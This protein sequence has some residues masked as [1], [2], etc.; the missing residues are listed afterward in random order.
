[1]KI[2]GAYHG[3][4]LK[5]SAKFHLILKISTLKNTRVRRL[6]SEITIE[7]RHQSNYELLLKPV[8]YN[9]RNKASVNNRI[10]LSMLSVLVWGEDLRRKLHSEKENGYSSKV[11]Q[12]IWRC[13][14]VFWNVCIKNSDAGE[15]PRRKHTT[16][17]YQIR[18]TATNFIWKLTFIFRLFINLFQLDKL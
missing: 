7:K 13:K 6:K 16:K 3:R 11:Y 1:M 9:L 5:P 10:F 2:C 4:R 8:Y 12:D 18:L 14:R 15:L 17:L